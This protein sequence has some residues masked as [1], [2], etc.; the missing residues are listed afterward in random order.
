[1]HFQRNGGRPLCP[2]TFRLSG[3]VER[4]HRVNPGVVDTLM[5][6]VVGVGALAD[7]GVLLD[8]RE[9]AQPV[10]GHLLV[11]VASLAGRGLGWLAVDL[12]LG[13]GVVMHVVRVRGSRAA[14]RCSGRVGGVEIVVARGRGRGVVVRGQGVGVLQLH[15]QAG[16][17]RGCCRRR[18]CRSA[19]RERGRAGCTAR[20]GGLP[21]PLGGSLLVIILV[22]L[23]AL[24]VLVVGALA[25]RGVVARA[26]P[27]RSARRLL[28]PNLDLYGRAGRRA[29]CAGAREE[30]VW[31]DEVGEGLDAGQRAVE[32]GGAVKDLCRRRPVLLDDD[33]P[34]GAQQRA[35]L[36][37]SLGPQRGVPAS[38]CEEG[39]RCVSLKSPSWHGTFGAGSRAR[40]RQ[41]LL[42][43]SL[44]EALAHQW[45]LI[46]FSLR[47]GR[48]LAISA[49]W[50]PTSLCSLAKMYSSRQTQ[51]SLQMSGLRSFF[52]F[53]RHCLPAVCGACAG[54]G[55]RRQL[56][57][58]GEVAALDLGGPPP[59][60]MLMLLRSPVRPGMNLAT[61]AQLMRSRPWLEMAAT[62]L[63]C[64]TSVHFLLGR[65]LKPTSDAVRGEDWLLCMAALLRDRR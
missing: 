13:S 26:L 16:E 58:M 63:A 17:M 54:R 49:H 65:L 34:V 40:Q 64:S 52:H 57:C 3:H 10:E 2:L 29:L 47:P 45:F 41:P 5:R 53:S 33:A 7:V 36:G 20:P 38:D 22:V 60:L 44:Q 62:K 6:D 23:E 28:A 14:D 9:E 21:A 46:E 39:E 32:L 31:H 30:L 11:V 27:R 15:G 48:N 19:R 55:A 50:L 8:R 4:A 24:V 18:C 12:D 37:L 61:S 43:G 42:T 1:M 35:P 25:L 56:G 51:G 59:S